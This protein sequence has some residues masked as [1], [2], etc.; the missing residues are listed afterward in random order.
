MISLIVLL[1]VFLSER[2]IGEPF[3]SDSIHFYIEHDGDPSTTS[4]AVTL[5]ATSSY[6]SD[7]DKLIIDSRDNHDG[8]ALLLHHGCNTS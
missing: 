5:D 3:N 4:G 6:D 8:N 2:D 1:K 7:G